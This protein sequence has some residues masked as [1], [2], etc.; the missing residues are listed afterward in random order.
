M[1]VV[2]IP[3]PSPVVRVRA[4]YGAETKV[5]DLAVGQEVAIVDGQRTIARVQIIGAL[6]AQGELTHWVKEDVERIR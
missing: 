1:I 4:I 2:D 5:A 3:N 6:D